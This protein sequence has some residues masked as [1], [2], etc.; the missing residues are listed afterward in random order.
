MEEKTFTT[1]NFDDLIITCAR[2]VSLSKE[3]VDGN[4]MLSQL[5]FLG[6]LIIE[7]AENPIIKKSGIIKI[8]S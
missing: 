5:M 3:S 7:F 8:E 6:K 1:E 4:M 2:I